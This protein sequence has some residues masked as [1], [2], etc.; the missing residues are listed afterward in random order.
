MEYVV[1]ATLVGAGLLYQKQQEVPDDRSNNETS[2]PQMRQTLYESNAF[3]FAKQTARQNADIHVPKAIDNIDSAR[4][5]A[6]EDGMID[7][8]S[9][10]RIHKS[11]FKH[12]NMK[13]FF[14]SKLTQNMNFDQNQS[15]LET[16]TGTMPVKPK[17]ETTPF[18]SNM[19]QQPLGRDLLEENAQKR[20]HIVASSYQRGVLPFEQQQVSHVGSYSIEERDAVMPRSIDELRSK[21]NPKNVYGGRVI[22]GK[23][24]VDDR[25][26][27][28]EVFRNRPQNDV[29]NKAILRTTGAYKKPEQHPDV[30]LRNTENKEHYFAYNGNA[31]PQNEKHGVVHSKVSDPHKQQLGAE[32]LTN[33]TAP[34]RWDENNE[35]SDYGKS[36]IRPADMNITEKRG[37]LSNVVTSVKA[38]IAPFQSKI[39]PTIREEYEENTHAGVLTGPTKIKTYDPDEARVTNRETTSM[40]SYTGIAES[41]DK[42]HMSSEDIANASFNELKEY[43]E[44]NRDP[45]QEG[46]KLMAGQ[47]TE[48]PTR[49]KSEYANHPSGGVTHIRSSIPTHSSVKRAR[50]RRTDN[51]HERDLIDTHLIDSLKTNPYA[52]DVKSLFK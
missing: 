38:L 14:G 5:V 9:G 35:L 13:P 4:H 37:T 22:A 33:L 28:P 6:F 29:E 15:L 21:T 44:T 8:L 50:E 27:L 32:G 40:R 1:V 12:K 20:S 49:E 10:E 31:A 45:T 41:K 3:N 7:T 36:S 43:L 26:L 46:V 48:N 52:T 2:S 47:E 30:I 11:Q 51:E 18:F 16:F 19:P 17:E 24:M 23:S 34:G 42:K 39:L 25:T